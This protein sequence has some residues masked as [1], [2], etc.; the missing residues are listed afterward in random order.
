MN[1]YGMHK[2]FKE[3]LIEQKITD[4]IAEDRLDEILS[5]PSFIGSAGIICDEILKEAIKN[6]KRSK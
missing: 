1:S 4:H 5:P 3:A 2:T 6:G